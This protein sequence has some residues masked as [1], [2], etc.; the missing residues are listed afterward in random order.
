M[1]IPRLKKYHAGFRHSLLLR[2]KGS[3]DFL[4][5]VVLAGQKGDALSSQ[6]RN[7]WRTRH[8]SNV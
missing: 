3:K 6:M 1:S 7:E 2:I 4:E 8:D 5:R